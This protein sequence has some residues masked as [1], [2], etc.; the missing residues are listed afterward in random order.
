MVSEHESSTSALFTPIWCTIRAN[1]HQFSSLPWANEQ[2]HFISRELL[3]SWLKADQS[4]ESRLWH[5][6]QSGISDQCITSKYLLLTR[7]FCCYRH[8]FKSG[9]FTNAQTRAL[10]Q[11]LR[12][13]MGDPGSSS[14][15]SLWKKVKLQNRTAITLPNGTIA[16]TWLIN[17]IPWQRKM[18]D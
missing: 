6:W 10:L 16:Q 18:W 7:H 2:R 13:V 5:P 17:W 1:K 15:L 14:G 11:L 3:T 8:N 9:T 12:V 4:K